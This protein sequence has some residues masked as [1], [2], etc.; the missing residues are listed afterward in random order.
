MS[1]VDERKAAQRRQV[2][3]GLRQLADLAEAH[4]VF[5][6]TL[7]SLTR[8]GVTSFGRDRELM[9]QVTK[10]CLRGGCQV[11]KE[12]T[13]TL[14]NLVITTPAG[15]KV[16]LLANREDVCERVVVGTHEV[17]EDVPDPTLLAAVPLVT[18][19][20]VEE[21]VEYRCSPLLGDARTE[22]AN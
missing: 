3:D 10:L 17:T 21:I 22:G 5:A 9:R 13:D 6:D 1:A 14:Y 16:K 11:E 15:V 7:S 18:Q 20:R 8:Y 12:V 19:T 4:P 2:V